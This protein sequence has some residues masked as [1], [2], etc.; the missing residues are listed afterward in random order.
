MNMP[1]FVTKPLG[2]EVTARRPISNPF[3]VSVGQRRKSEI[4]SNLLRIVAIPPA[5]INPDGFQPTAS[6]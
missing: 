1:L 2:R 6:W 4:V 3:R 5:M